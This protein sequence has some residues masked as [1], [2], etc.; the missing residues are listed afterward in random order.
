[1]SN[2]LYTA[3]VAKSDSVTNVVYE[4]V[5]HVWW[6]ENGQVLGIE[7]GERGKDRSYVYYPACH[8]DHVHIIEENEV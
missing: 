6:Q 2:Q 5:L 4:H 7:M 1:M 8:V 3:R